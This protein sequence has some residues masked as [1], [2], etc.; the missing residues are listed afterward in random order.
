MM[1]LIIYT[2]Q[3][4]FIVLDVVVLLY[5]LRSF[6][7][8]FPFGDYIVRLLAVLMTPMWYPMQWLIKHSILYTAKFDLCPYLLIVVLTYLQGLCSRIMNIL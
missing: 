4:F 8:L 7:V 6:L 1:Q 5:L 2:F 3:C